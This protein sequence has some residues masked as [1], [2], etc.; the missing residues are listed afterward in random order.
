MRRPSEPTTLATKAVRG[1]VW[2]F[3]TTL[4]VRLVSLLS[5]AILT[6]LLVP[7]QFGLMA[8]GLVFLTYVET[9][10]DLGTGAA[11]IYWPK[12][13]SDASEVTFWISLLTG[14]FWFGVT[15]AGAAAL[16]LFFHAPQA[17]PLIR[18]LALCFPIRALGRT[19][20]SLCQKDLRFKA[21][22]VPESAMYITKGIVAISLAV[23][24]MGVWSLVWGQLVGEVLRTLSL[25]LVVPWRPSLSLPIDLVGPVLRYGRGI[26]AVNLLAAVLHHADLVV[27]GRRLGAQDL[28]L[29]QIAAKVPEITVALLIWGGA[30][31]LFPTLSKVQHSPAQLRRFYLEALRWVAVL[32]MPATVGLYLLAKPLLVTFFGDAWLPAVPILRAL[33]IYSGLR[34]LGSHTG[35]VMKAT[36]RSQLLAGLGVAKAFLLLPALVWASSFGAQAVAWSLTVVSA[37]GLILNV[38][39]VSHLLGLRPRALLNSLQ[40]ALPGTLVTLVFLGIWI[41]ISIGMPQVVVL[42]GG[43]SFGLLLCL[44]TLRWSSPEHF[45]AAVE[46]LFHRDGSPIPGVVEPG[47]LRPGTP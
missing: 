1:A 6:R 34:A 5:L 15:Q 8:L 44:V 12:R 4:A 37:V 35:D 42:L 3:A 27:V 23:A 31:V 40:T 30:K 46:Q 19:H 29:Y 2:S 20:D 9:V 14:L 32:S 17:E 16:A 11:L 38:W 41:H 25:W 43:V 22:L 21:R 10:G 28:G 33:A 18:A 13:R 24:G 47:I 45:H 26:I 7:E 36:G 39:V